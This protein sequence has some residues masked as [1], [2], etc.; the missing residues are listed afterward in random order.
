M[1]KL[2]REALS[3]G[4]HPAT[5]AL[6]NFPGVEK[7]LDDHVAGRGYAMSTLWTLVAFRL[8]AQKYNATL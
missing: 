3:P 6:I 5:D 4:F 1:L 2:V 8:W 7:M